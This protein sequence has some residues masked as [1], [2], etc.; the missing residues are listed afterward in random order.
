VQIRWLVGAGWGGGEHSWI[1]CG[2]GRDACGWMAWAIG[3]D[4]PDRWEA[5]RYNQGR[6]TTFAALISSR[7]IY[8][9]YFGIL[10]NLFVCLLSNPGRVG[11]TIVGCQAQHIV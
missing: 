7:D 6:Q 3:T 10:Y 8:I 1:L 5:E 4:G 2:E 11:A 9:M